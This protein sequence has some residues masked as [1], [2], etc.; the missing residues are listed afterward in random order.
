MNSFI[1]TRKNRGNI[2]IALLKLIIFIIFFV[3]L[4]K[5]AQ[6]YSM[7]MMN[8]FFNKE[9]TKVPNLISRDS[10]PVRIE[11]A[12]ELCKQSRLRMDIKD[13]KFDNNIP[14]GCVIS[15]DP[16]PDQIVKTN[17]MV[18]VIISKGAKTEECPDVVGKDVREVMFT[19]QTKGFALGKKSAIYSETV[20][21]DVVI[22]QTPEGKSQAPKGSQVD[23]LVSQGKA[24]KNVQMPNFVGKKIEAARIVLSKIN[25]EPGTIGYEAQE[26]SEP[27]TVLK[28]EP[29]PGT[30]V[31]DKSQVSFIVTEG[32]ENMEP[33]KVISSE[34]TAPVTIKENVK[35]EPAAP[36]TG[37]V[38]PEIEGTSA[39]TPVTVR[40]EEA[41]SDKTA[42]DGKKVE[43]IKFIVPP[44][45]KSREIKMV[46][47][48]DQG[49]REIYRDYHYPAEE[50]DLTITGYGNM[51]VLIY[52]DNVFFKDIEAGGKQ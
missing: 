9:E 33:P 23:L 11:D 20:P 50:I 51:K 41:K 27:G 52:L 40:K 5:F 13:K 38:K 47:L 3:V 21:E 44:G 6:R 22:A 49:P 29:A 17:R 25:L 10:S 4:F 28:Q 36:V 48:D 32:P 35:N 34:Q 46:L 45:Q 15:Q 8:S 7:Q 12:F 31:P 24:N 37:E 42:G 2:L 14:E 26:G 19:I 39:T 1:H 18:E 43:I 16:P 30:F